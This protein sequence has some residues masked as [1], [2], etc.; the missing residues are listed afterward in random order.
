MSG[1]WRRQA[2]AA[3][4][5]AHKAIPESASLAERT[6]AIDAAYPFVVRQYYPYKIWLEERR[7]YLGRFGHQ[8]KG[9]PKRDPW[10]S[11]LDRAKRRAMEKSK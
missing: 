4:S 11:P 10:E 7:D 1:Y 5:A 2:K 3:I 8:S 6:A 9:K